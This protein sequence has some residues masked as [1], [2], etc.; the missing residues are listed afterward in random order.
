MISEDKFSV[1]LV[2]TNVRSFPEGMTPPMIE[3]A[4]RTYL[5]ERESSS[6]RRGLVCYRS[7]LDYENEEAIRQALLR[8]DEEDLA[9]KDSSDAG[10]SSEGVEF[11]WVMPN[12]S[13]S[14]STEDMVKNEVARL[15]IV[16]RYLLLE[17]FKMI[18]NDSIKSPSSRALDKLTSLACSLFKVPIALISLMD[19][20]QQVILSSG[21]AKRKELSRDFPI[22]VPRAQTF[23]GHLLAYDC[24]PQNALLLVPDIRKDPRFSGKFLLHPVYQAASFYAGCPLVSPEGIKIGTFWYVF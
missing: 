21:S 5:L 15:L 4:E 2:S 14:I 17:D 12:I 24:C 23:C 7:V 1:H 6:S 3:D 19:L 22:M 18:Q 8:G 16:R 10:E 13:G 9:D 11:D 20:G